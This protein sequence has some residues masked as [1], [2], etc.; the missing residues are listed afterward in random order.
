MSL[1]STVSLFSGSKKV[2]TKIKGSLK[3]S[4]IT[5][6]CLLAV[7]ADPLMTNAA[8]APITETVTP[9]VDTVRPP[10]KLKTFRA[11]ITQYS[12]ADSCHF[13]KNGKCL[14]ASG[15]EVYEGAVACPS[16]MRLGAIVVIA[17]QQ[18]TCEDRYSPWLD[19]VRGLPTIDIFV[20][21]NPRGRYTTTVSTPS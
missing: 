8:L 18:Y 10:V 5:L 11:V 6:V 9:A 4:L 1:S 12:R 13:K 3:P 21:Q 17:E 19:E 2:I 7:M 20:N 16:F 15:K 14:M